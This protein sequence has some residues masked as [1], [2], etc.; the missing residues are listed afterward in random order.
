MANVAS[1]GKMTYDRASQWSRVE[2]VLLAQPDPDNYSHT[3]VFDVGADDSGAY[4]Q[5]VF[6]WNPPHND[7]AV[8]DFKKFLESDHNINLV[9]FK[10]IGQPGT[11]SV[12]RFVFT[13]EPKPTF[14]SYQLTNMLIE[15]IRLWFP[16]VQ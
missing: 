5:G 7:K 11:G 12:I 15:A 13:L 2:G 16:I 6:H 8:K 14:N 10:N 4:M 3:G 9:E 1:K